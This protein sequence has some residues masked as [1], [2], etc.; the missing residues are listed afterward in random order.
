MATIEFLLQEDEVAVRA[1][2][3]EQENLRL[4]FEGKF[5]NTR[6]LIRVVVE[7]LRTEIEHARIV[8]LNSKLVRNPFAA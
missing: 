2:L 5:T 7:R 8:A 3:L 6:V 4:R 1:A